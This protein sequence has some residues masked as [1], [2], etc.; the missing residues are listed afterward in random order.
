MEQGH[1]P[2]RMLK[3]GD[4]ALDFSLTGQNGK[5]VRL[6]GDRG[7]RN[8]VLIFYP[9]N[10]TP[11]HTRQLHAVRDQFELFRSNDTAVFGVSG[12]FE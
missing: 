7:K 1:G 8:V 11:G 2:S 3:V 4:Q 6:G 10:K 5:L 9:G 12:A